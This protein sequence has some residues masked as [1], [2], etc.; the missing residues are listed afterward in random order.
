MKLNN[1]KKILIV[2]ICFLSIVDSFAQETFQQADLVGKKWKSKEFRE[3]KRSIKYTKT[4]ETVVNRNIFI[5]T[6]KYYLSDTIDSV[7]DK[8]KVGKS[9]S[10]RYVVVRNKRADN[11]IKVNEILALT[12]NTLAMT[13]SFP[14]TYHTRDWYKT[15]LENRKITQQTFLQ[16]DIVDKKWILG[17]GIYSYNDFFTEYKSNGKC[18]NNHFTLNGKEKI[19]EY[20]YYLSDSIGTFFDK[21]RVGKITSGSYIIQRD[22]DGYTYIF[23]ILRVTKDRLIL[24]CLR[25]FCS[26]WEGIHTFYLVED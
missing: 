15:P 3:N 24:N 2:I 23:E 4:K 12:E 1:F 11:G 10:G 18:I 21:S 8:S 19:M 6:N 13:G 14:S 7:F 26:F 25:E 5:S 16:S 22:S 20:E 9:R 17:N